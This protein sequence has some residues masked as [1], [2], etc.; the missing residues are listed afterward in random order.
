MQA[1]LSFLPTSAFL[2]VAMPDEGVS[3]PGAL[4]F[5][6]PKFIKVTASV[7]A[8]ATVTSA[9]QY[10]SPGEN[11]AVFGTVAGLAV[12]IPLAAAGV[13]PNVVIPVTAGAVA[14]AAGGA[15]IIA[16]HQA[17][18]RQRK[19]AEQRARLYMA[20]RAEEEKK[21]AQVAAAS[22]SSSSKKQTAPQKSRY[23]AVTTEK[24]DFNTG[25]SA[26]MI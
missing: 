17:T 2:L 24:E 21:A 6:N 12:G 26:V 23:I 10:L 9:C 16:K 25:Q 19:I 4:S 20:K 1:A 14:L 15:Y 11:A 5:M 22:S 8:L 7:A 18:E 3:E 13:N